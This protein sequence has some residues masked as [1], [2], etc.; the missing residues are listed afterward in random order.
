MTSPHQPTQQ[1]AWDD[2]V[3]PFQLDHADIRGRVARL[4]GVLDGILKQHDYPAQVEALVAEMA[5][6][7]A[8]IGQ[9]MKLRWKLSLQVQSKGPVRMIAT[10]YYGPDEDGRSARIR[11]YASYDA[12]RLTDGAPID[13]VGEGYFAIMIDQGEGMTPYQGITPLTG[14]SLASCAEAYFAQS[15]QLPT[16]FS[17]SFGQSSGP[18]EAEHWRAGGVMLQHMP[19]ASPFAAS[20]EGNG[21]VLSASDLVNGDEEENWN[22][23]N[24]LLN[25]VEDLELIGPSVPPTDLLLRLFHEEQPRV[26]DAQAVRFGCTCSEDRVRQSLS[27]Y[28]AKDIEKMTTDDGRV[29]ADCQFCGAHYDLDPASVGFEAETDGA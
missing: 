13:Q 25:T 26:F 19:K 4:D 21:D 16:R 12:D 24:M 17:L 6:L 2:S 20:G 11:A 23:V 5:L 27:I 10:D 1:L 15:E 28:S 3:L 22:R 18:N 29:T 7:T 14:D 8:L 9:T